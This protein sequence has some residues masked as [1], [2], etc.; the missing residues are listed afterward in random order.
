VKLL[1]DTHV[2]LWL[3]GQPD[4]LSPRAAELL[5]DTRNEVSVSSISALEIATKHRL[6]RLPTA[7][8]LV[9]DY[10]GV[11][12][13]LE[14]LDLPLTQVHASLAGRLEWANRDPFDRIIAAAAMAEG[15]VLVTKDSAFDSL[16]GVAT[17][18]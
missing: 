5:C 16:P 6:G 8:R 2:L 17:A 11:L 7:A 18:W 1:A 4:K 9:H 14:L 13:G 10:P 15:C 12:A 3:A